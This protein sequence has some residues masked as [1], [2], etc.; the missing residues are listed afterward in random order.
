MLLLQ[1]DLKDIRDDPALMSIQLMVANNNCAMVW[2]LPR[3]REP[4]LSARHGVF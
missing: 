1:S 4:G 3:G 2:L